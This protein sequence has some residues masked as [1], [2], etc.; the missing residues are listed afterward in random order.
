MSYKI[1]LLWKY[2]CTLITSKFEL[3][4]PSRANMRYDR[5]ISI[6]P[7]MLVPNEEQENK[8][9]GNPER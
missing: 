1:F 4:C 5:I 7:V 3:K 9:R 6:Y 8:S 2:A